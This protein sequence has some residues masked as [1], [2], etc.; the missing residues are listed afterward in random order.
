M[1][2]IVKLSVDGRRLSRSGEGER[3][4]TKQELER[5]IAAMQ[6]VQRANPPTSEAWQR[7]SRVLHELVTQLTGKAPRDACGRV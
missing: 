5:G 4:M 6:A 2:W 1:Y 7:A 3:D